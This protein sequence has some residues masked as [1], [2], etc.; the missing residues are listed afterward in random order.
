[1]ATKKPACEG[2]LFSWL[3]GGNHEKSQKN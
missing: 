1:M 3:P 2:W